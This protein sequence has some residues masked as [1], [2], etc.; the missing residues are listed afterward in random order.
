MTVRELTNNM[1][2]SQKISIVDDRNKEVKME[3]MNYQLR[4]VVNNDLIKREVVSFGVNEDG[5]IQI[6]VKYD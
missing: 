3:G 1:W 5:I 6:N 2:Y 4:S